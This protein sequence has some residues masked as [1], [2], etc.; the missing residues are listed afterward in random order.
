MLSHYPPITL[1]SIFVGDAD[2][3][4][5]W[6]NGDAHPCRVCAKRWGGYVGDKDFDVDEMMHDEV[7]AR[8]GF[9]GLGPIVRGVSKEYEYEDDPA[10]DLDDENDPE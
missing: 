9:V 3:Q 5:C 1:A 8:V 7:Y 6:H 10:R 4:I 2:S